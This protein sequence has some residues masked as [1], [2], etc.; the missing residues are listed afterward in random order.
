MN[1]INDSAINDFLKRRLNIADNPAPAST[2]APEVMPVFQIQPPSQEDDFLRGMRRCGASS[3]Q[4]ADALNYSVAV[5]QNPATSNLL[6][7]LDEVFITRMTDTAFTLHYVELDT[8]IPGIGSFGTTSLDSRWPLRSGFRSAAIFRSGLTTVA[9][10][11]SW[12]QW[13]AID[14]FASN[15]PQ[16][17]NPGVTL[18]PGTMYVIYTNGLNLPLGVALRWRER[19]Y[20]PSELG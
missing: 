5:L 15:A 19:P 13:A 10:H 12:V 1:E 20:Q 17:L 8:F 2:L 4:V 7:M 6:V 18:R 11:I 9:P 16:K 14:Y 3:I